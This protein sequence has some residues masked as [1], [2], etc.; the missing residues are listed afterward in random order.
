[1]NKKI[2]LQLKLL[3]ARNGRKRAE[4]LKKSGFFYGIGE[5]CYWHPYK[6]PHEGY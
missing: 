3:L 2:L 1:M 4:I 6:I 5:N